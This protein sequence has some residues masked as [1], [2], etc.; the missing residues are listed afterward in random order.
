MQCEVEVRFG[1]ITSC[2]VREKPTIGV[3]LVAVTAAPALV[4][5]ITEGTVITTGERGAAGC[6][7]DINLLCEDFPSFLHRCYPDL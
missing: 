1:V 2:L 6:A 4:S 3:R 5:A 7:K